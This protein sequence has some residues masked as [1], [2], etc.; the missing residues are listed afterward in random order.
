MEVPIDCLRLLRIHYR[1]QSG[2]IRI[3]HRLQRSEMLE[4]ARASCVSDSGN[5]EQFAMPVANLAPL[6]VIGDRESVSFIAHLLDQVQRRR[7][8]VE[9][10]GI[11]LLSVEVK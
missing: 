3:P 9:N 1:L 10:D 5:I 2:C 7:V 4:Q 8:S 6:P 11:L